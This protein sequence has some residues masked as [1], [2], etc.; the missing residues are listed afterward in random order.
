MAFT[1]QDI[2][3]YERAR[4]LSMCGLKETDTLPD[5]VLQTYMTAKFAADRVGQ[6]F[7]DHTLLTIVLCSRNRPVAPPPPTV[8][9]LYRSGK[10]KH[11]D[12][13]YCQW[14]KEKAKEAVLL[15]VTN[16]NEVEVRFVGGAEEYKLPADKVSLEK[17]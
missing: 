9:D 11:G 1:E 15:G 16:Q 12:K 17:E 6:P 8:V 5:D 10:A 4:L 2:P 14:R 3:E 7:T 13:V